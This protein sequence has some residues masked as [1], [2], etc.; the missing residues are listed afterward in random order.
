MKILATERELPG[1]TPERFQ[2]H[3][4]A[5][6]A[7]V[8]ELYKAE[9]IRELYFDRDHHT[10]VLMLEAAS[11]QAARQLL[12]TLPL[13]KEQLITFDLIP[14]VPYPGFARLFERE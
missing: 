8:W 13:V 12:A 9:L 6:A 5:E 7:Q 10:A 4:K 3:L 14:L 11:V 1:A 2:A